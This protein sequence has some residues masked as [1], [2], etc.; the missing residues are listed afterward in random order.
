MGN[1]TKEGGLP[2]RKV[3]SALGNLKA[4]ERVGSPESD[5]PK[6]ERAI[7]LRKVGTR[8]KSSTGPVWTYVLGGKRLGDQVHM[9][10]FR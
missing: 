6:R 3:P 1:R 9:G 2:A 8:Q 4:Q 10:L 7:G 5:S